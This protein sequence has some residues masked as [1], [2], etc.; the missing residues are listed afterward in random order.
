MYVRAV[1]TNA[2]TMAE[3]LLADGAHIISGGTDNHLILL[4]VFGSYGL[5]GKEAEVILENIGISTNKNMIP[6]DTR[7]PMD[8]SGI[9]IGTPAITTRGFDQEATKQLTQIIIQALRHPQDATLHTTL[10]E[11][12]LALCK[13]F[14]IPTH[15]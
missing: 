13:K 14:P 3:I 8:P 9:R 10:K 4:D 2:Q 6:F 1:I 5:S 11:Q 15:H 12:V 7:K